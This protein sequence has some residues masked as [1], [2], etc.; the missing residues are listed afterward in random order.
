MDLPL[1]TIPQVRRI[2]TIDG[3]GIKGVFPA[4]FIAEMEEQ[5]GD[6]IANYFDMI[7][8]TSTG[9]IIAL[10]LGLGMTGQEILDLYSKNAKRIFPRWLSSNLRGIFRSKYTNKVLRYVLEEVFEDRRLG[11]SQTR[12]LIPSLNLASERVHLYK[13]A[14]HPD[15]VHDYRSRAV[16]VALATVAAPTYFPIHLSPDGI[17]YIDGSVWA[18]NPLGLAV[19]EA[20]GVLG[21][22][23]DAIRVLSLGCTNQRLDVPWQKRTSYGASYWGARLAQVFTAAQS[24]SAVVTANVLI[25]ATNL[26]RVSPDMSAERFTLDGVRHLDNLRHLGETE[27]AREF[28]RLKPMFFTGKAPKFVPYHHQMSPDRA[29]SPRCSAYA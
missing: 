12:L 11:E 23:R 6:R 27:A 21:W 29:V 4:A 15:L 28:S 3:G 7:A 9:G 24:S 8:G 22:P 14:H 10:A 25:G 26:Y 18:H 5:L 17:P 20:V 13:T 1:E 19:I 2:L 16:E